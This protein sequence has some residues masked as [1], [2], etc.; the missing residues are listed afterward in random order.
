[1]I[2]LFTNAVCFGLSSVIATNLVSKY[3]LKIIMFFSCTGYSL[4]VMSGIFIAYCSDHPDSGVFYCKK[5]F[6]PGLAIFGA[7]TSGL[8]GGHIWL[9]NAAYI[10]ALASTA[11]SYRGR[12]YGTFIGTY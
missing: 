1:M 4:F 2:V 3:S 11:P 9:A 6:I 10:D 12:Y 8:C 7:I 5:G